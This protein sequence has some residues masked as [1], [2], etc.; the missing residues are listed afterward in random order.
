M[1]MSTYEK[2]HVHYETLNTGE[3][4]SYL[5]LSCNNRRLRRRRWTGPSQSRS[6]GSPGIRKIADPNYCHCRRC[7]CRP[8]IRINTGAAAPHLHPPQHQDQGGPWRGAA[9]PLF[10]KPGPGLGLGLGWLG[11]GVGLTVGDWHPKKIAN[12]YQLV[13]SEDQGRTMALTAW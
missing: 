5:C 9:Q 1:S 6:A 3:A 2:G 10:F 12:D 4:C 11:S 7:S 13:Q 8:V